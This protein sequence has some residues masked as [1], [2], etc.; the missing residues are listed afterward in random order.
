MVLPG[1]LPARELTEV[2]SGA[3]TKPICR[4]LFTYMAL[5]RIP[6]GSDLSVNF[7]K[8]ESG[9][10]ALFFVRASPPIV[11]RFSSRVGTS[12]RPGVPFCPSPPF[13]PAVLLRLFDA[14]GL[15]RPEPALP[16]ARSPAV[17]ALGPERLAIP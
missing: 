2:K 3:S 11:H 6:C 14:G 1:R 8:L 15:L 16:P 7:L 17:W 12:V 4:F 13:C 9:I 10:S 5:G